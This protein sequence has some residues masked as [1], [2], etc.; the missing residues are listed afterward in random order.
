MHAQLKTWQASQLGFSR[1]HLICVAAS[2]VRACVRA[3]ASR[4][5]PTHLSLAT[6]LAVHRLLDLTA[7]A[8]HGQAVD[9]NLRSRGH[10]VEDVGPRTGYLCG[11]HQTPGLMLLRVHGGGGDPAR[12]QGGRGGEGEGRRTAAAA[13]REDARVVNASRRRAVLP[14]CLSARLSLGS[15]DQAPA[16]RSCRARAGSAAA[17]APPSP[18]PPPFV[19]SRMHST[20]L[21]GEAAGYITAQHMGKVN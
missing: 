13:A 11:R 1:L 3:L 19:W 6:A 9:A 16:R 8:A 18:P 12:G 7:G 20:S 5:T 14:V 21:G 2:V 15:S 10:G 17:A 4:A